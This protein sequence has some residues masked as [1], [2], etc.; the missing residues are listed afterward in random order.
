MPGAALREVPTARVASAAVIGKLLA[1]ITA[2]ELPAGPVPPETRV[3]ENALAVEGAL[4]TAIRALRETSAVSRRMA[5]VP[6]LTYARYHEKAAEADIASE[7][8]RRLISRL[9]LIATLPSDAVR[10]AGNPPDLR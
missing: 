6:G 7:T 10:S 5:D 1:E 4:W 8:I 3:D 2:A 9:A